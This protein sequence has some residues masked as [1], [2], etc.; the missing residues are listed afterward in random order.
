MLIKYFQIK[1]Y[2]KLFR[3]EHSIAKPFVGRM[4]QKVDG[5]FILKFVG[6]HGLKSR[7]I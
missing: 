3:F 7:Y 4:T 6:V 5:N 2:I 1:V